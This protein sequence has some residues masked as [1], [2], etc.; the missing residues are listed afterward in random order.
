MITELVLNQTKALL[1]VLIN[2]IP[3]AT[4]LQDN[5]WIV[6]TLTLLNK[7]LYFFP[8]DVWWLFISNLSFWLTAQLTWACI[9]WAYKKI[10]GIK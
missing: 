9:E 8:Q 3:Q 5:G 10:P 6:S 4:N 1:L 7:A 2:M